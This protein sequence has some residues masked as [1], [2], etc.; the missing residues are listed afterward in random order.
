MSILIHVI[1]TTPNFNLFLLYQGDA[2]SSQRHTSVDRLPPDRKL[3][4]P[5]Q[6]IINFVEDYV[7]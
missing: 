5:D 1:V 7:E 2:Y 6:V 3:S 4:L